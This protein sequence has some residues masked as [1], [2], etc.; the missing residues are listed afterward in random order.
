MRALILDILYGTLLLY[1]A[2][3]IHFRFGA[4]FGTTNINPFRSDG[5]LFKTTVLLTD[6]LINRHTAFP[7]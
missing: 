1:F 3:T 4:A 7:C 6:K 2:F 5:N